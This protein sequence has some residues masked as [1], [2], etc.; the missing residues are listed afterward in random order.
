M[1][2]Q[3]YKR[4]L[5]K[6]AMID[7][8]PW[9]VFAR[10]R[11]GLITATVPVID[12]KIVVQLQSD[13]PPNNGY[14]AA[15]VIEPGNSD[16]AVDAV[17][18]WRRKRFLERWPCRTS[19][20]IPRSPPMSRCASCLRAPIAAIIPSGTRRCRS[21]RISRA[22]RGGIVSVDFLAFSNQDDLMPNVSTSAPDGI[23]PQVRWGKWTSCGATWRRTAH[24]HVR[25]A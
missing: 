24:H 23:T 25:R 19:R 5:W 22:P 14:L 10:S 15:M 17:E 2:G 9:E 13:Q 8:G 21:R 1:G 7:G 12:N 20:S 16:K 6:E 3:V 4:N 18:A 11:A